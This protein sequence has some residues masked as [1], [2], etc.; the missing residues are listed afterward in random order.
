MKKIV[1]ILIL[2]II[3]CVLFAYSASDIYFSAHAGAQG[4]INTTL[5]AV[6]AEA[7][8]TA[9]LSLGG[10]LTYRNALHGDFSFTYK[11]F[12][13]QYSRFTNVPKYT[14][15]C[16]GFGWLYKGDIFLLAVDG[17]LA[18]VKVGDNWEAGAYLDATPKFIITA[19]DAVGRMAL[20][21][22]VQFVYTG[23]TYRYGVGVAISWEIYQ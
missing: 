1:L 13:K 12:E 7:D 9:K 16:L 8:L 22:P 11:V 23:N 14:Q 21:F 5:G 4:A 17:G 6:V 10:F 19:F 20:G 15:M 2:T 3:P 18:V